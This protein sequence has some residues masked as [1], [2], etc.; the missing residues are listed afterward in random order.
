MLMK[1]K[2]KYIPILLIILSLLDLRI[3][4]R[5]LLDQFTLTSF[6]YAFRHHT[7]AFTILFFSPSLIK[8]YTKYKYYANRS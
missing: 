8:T 2:R 3:E 5:I 1:N 4:M 6:I 7:L